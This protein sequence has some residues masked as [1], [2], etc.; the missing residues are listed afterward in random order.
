[1]NLLSKSLI[2]PTGNL[3]FEVPLSSIEPKLFKDKEI[4]S[5][6]FNVSSNK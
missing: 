4:P 2:L 1:M 3:N 5:T 6:Y